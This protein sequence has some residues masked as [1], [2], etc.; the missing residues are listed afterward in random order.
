MTKDI[1]DEAYDYWIGQIYQAL[2][3][4]EDQAQR[5]HWAE[6]RT[7]SLYVQAIAAALTVSRK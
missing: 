2:H 1:D 5:G 3:D 4:A 7:Y 6:S